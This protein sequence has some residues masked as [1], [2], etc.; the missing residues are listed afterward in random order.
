MISLTQGVAG[1]WVGVSCHFLG[2]FSEI[3][4]MTYKPASVWLG[5]TALCDVII[6]A[7]M[8]YYLMTVQTGFA[9]TKL[10][11]TRVVRVTI[12][13]GFICAAFAV[14]DL[15]FY[16]RF[17]NNN[18]HLAPSI[19][20]SKLYSNSLLVVLNSRVRFVGGRDHSANNDLFISTPGQN[21]SNTIGI[22]ISH[23]VVNSETIQMV[24]PYSN[25][26][27]E[28]SKSPQPFE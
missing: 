24:R 1:I 8:L 22:A 17:P 11:I 2:K 4:N 28:D 20:L 25:V 21:I 10:L 15:S 3:Q 23:E 18:Y 13:T 27:A 6:A 16:V 26:G 5:G 7:A 9:A 12:E 19:A 14:L